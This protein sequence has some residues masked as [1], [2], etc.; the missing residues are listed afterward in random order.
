[1]EINNKGVFIFFLIVTFLSP[2]LYFDFCCYLT[3]FLLSI[4]GRSR[5][6]TRKEDGRL[7]VLGT[8]SRRRP[9]RT[10]E[11]AMNFLVV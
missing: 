5:A 9:S 7:E 6:L 4:V 10:M 8:P 3:L 2:S 11:V 1:M